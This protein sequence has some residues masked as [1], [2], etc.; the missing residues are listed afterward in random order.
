[1]P[2]SKY[3]IEIPLGG[4]VDEG[5]VPEIVQPPLVLEAEDCA[6]IKGGAYQK[7]DEISRDGSAAPDGSYALQS[8]SSGVYIANAD[9]VQRR[10]GASSADSEVHPGS[11]RN[12][13]RTVLGDSPQVQWWHDTAEQGGVIAAVWTETGLT[14]PGNK[15]NIS[16]GATASVGISPETPD[17]P[18][19]CWGSSEFLWNDPAAVGVPALNLGGEARLDARLWF[20]TYD[21][22]TKEQLGPAK[23]ITRFGEIFSVPTSAAGEPAP[24]AMMPR[25]RA[26]PGTSL[27]CIG[28]NGMPRNGA[29]PW[30]RPATVSPPGVSLGANAYRTGDYGVL[31]GNLNMGYRVYLVD[32]NGDF[33]TAEI[34]PGPGEGGDIET[35]FELFYVGSQLYTLTYQDNSDLLAPGN[36]FPPPPTGNVGTRLI[37][38]AEY[39]IREWTGMTIPAPPLLVATVTRTLETETVA[40][41][42]SPIPSGAVRSLPSGMYYITVAGAE[43]L[44]VVLS[45]GDL[46]D[47]TLAPLAYNATTT[48]AALMDT[49][50]CEPIRTRG[51]PNDPVD[52]G[53]AGDPDALWQYFPTTTDCMKGWTGTSSFL[54]QR[55]GGGFWLGLQCQRMVDYPGGEPSPLLSP[56]IPSLP[57]LEGYRVPGP[58]PGLTPAENLALRQRW[59]YDQTLGGVPYSVPVILHFFLDDD[60]I[61]DESSAGVTVGSRIM[62]DAVVYDGEPV[63]GIEAPVPSGAVSSYCFGPTLSGVAGSRISADAQLPSFVVARRVEAG[64]DNEDGDRAAARLVAMA[65]Y[66]EL[67]SNPGTCIH[68][69]CAHK[70]G[71]YVTDAGELA[72]SVDVFGARLD[73]NSFSSLWTA[74]LQ[75]GANIAYTIY[76]AP[77]PYFGYQPC[78]RGDLLALTRG[79]GHLVALSDLQ[80]N[81]KA[82][83]SEQAIFGGSA[84]FSSAGPASTAA[85]PFLQNWVR[86]PRLQREKSERE[87]PA[88][89]QW[90]I[91]FQLPDPIPAPTDQ[92]D[93]TQWDIQAYSHVVWYDES[94]AQHRSLPSQGFFPGSNFTPATYGN[95]DSTYNNIEYHYCPIPWELMGVP[96]E[97]QMGTEA[98]LALVGV[99]A[100]GVTDPPLSPIPTEIGTTPQP[101]VHSSVDFQ[102]LV[103]R[104]STA[105][106]GTGQ[107][108]YTDAGELG[109]GPLPGVK[110]L[111][112]TTTRVWA[113]GMS[114]PGRVF[115][116]KLRRPGYSTEWNGN[117]YLDVADPEPLTAVAGLPDGRMLF[118]TAHAVYYSLG[119]GPSDTGQGAG[120]SQPSLLSDDVGCVDAR[121]IAVGDFGVMFKGDRGYYVV[122]RALSLTFA[123]L[124]YEDTAVGPVSSAAVDGVR[125]E[126]LLCRTDGQPRGA[127]VYNY[128]RG[129][130][131]TF[132]APWGDCYDAT[133]RNGRPL[134]LGDT[135]GAPGRSLWTPDLLPARADNGDPD[136][137]QA[138]RTGWLAMGKIQG[139][140]RVWEAQLTGSRPTLSLSGLRVEVLYDYDLTPAEVYDFDD[141]GSDPFKVRFRPRR[142]KCEAIAFRFS[143]YVPSGADPEECTGWRLEMCTVLAGVKA[144]LDKV[145]VTVRSS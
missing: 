62:T 35:L 108:L 118:F 72:F 125:S 93:L 24:F 121:T 68:N 32:S 114:E 136:A 134:A 126:V 56:A 142:Q 53:G 18:P 49:M 104:G 47:F 28:V 103:S 38:D 89:R 82:A 48:F 45:D 6:S 98:Y 74:S 124:P 50:K 27:W 10:E 2:L 31:N 88:Y 39:K 117:L 132:T 52:A 94:P 83:S 115:Y 46:D 36:P 122:D 67:S 65:T 77:A 25:V 81:P 101:L 21:A 73:P 43:R 116:S 33:Q 30:A 7:R 4:A 123:G 76:G 141:V 139:F 8:A 54:V 17:V 113:V 110:D 55:P 86:W 26:V 58:L 140:G 69:F 106:R 91:G 128:L 129:Q 84:P 12:I 137:L 1:M 63:V 29:I 16:A 135:P 34:G 20:A 60:F 3:P 133:S 138:L 105:L 19:G 13:E 95:V 44:Q 11:R 5:N 51:L 144:G 97:Q 119:E 23:D 14:L 96:F 112:A 85:A 100:T 99:S 143:E 120:F 80:A 71:M 40:V 107:A 41:P 66:A 64:G 131:S 145:A 70:S 15:S 75:S 59:E 92:D 127:F 42:P 102:Q 9:T 111:C 79:A 61:V 22:V 57:W 37:A 90:D 130:W 78:L 109:A 87:Q